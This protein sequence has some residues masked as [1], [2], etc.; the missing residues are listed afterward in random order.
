LLVRSV[1]VVVVAL[2][3]RRLGELFL[4]SCVRLHGV[5]VGENEVEDFGVPGYRLA[6][7]TFFDVL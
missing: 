4:P 3:F 2:L 7:D 6:F 5:D 1:A